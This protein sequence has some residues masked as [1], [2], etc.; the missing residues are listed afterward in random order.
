MKDLKITLLLITVIVILL[1]FGK[2]ENFT[3]DA[4]VDTFLNTWQLTNKEISKT[5]ELSDDKITFKKPINTNSI[6]TNSI[7]GDS[8]DIRTKNSPI[9]F[10]K[11]LNRDKAVSAMFTLNNGLVI[12]SNKNWA[13]I[14]SYKN[15]EG[16]TVRM[17]N[18]GDSHIG[19]TNN[20]NYL[21]GD[22]TN[23]QNKL[24]IGGTCI[25]ENHLKV[26]TGGKAFSI[27]SDQ[28]DKRLEN[29][30]DNAGFWWPNPKKTRNTP[31]DDKT[32]QF[33]IHAIR[34]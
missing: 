11:D 16:L 30:N 21:R 3:K 2:K 14:D 5:M 9:I 7:F 8:L 31:I 1:W 23:I 17:P 25:D 15:H 6:N 18:G 32:Q 12:S 20:Q 34:G 33:R 28:D 22:Q 26:L 27:K 24:C 4:N 10:K 29:Y 19:W 13:E